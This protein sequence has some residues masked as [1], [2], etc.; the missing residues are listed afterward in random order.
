MK[1]ILFVA[2][3]SI[4][5]ITSC[6]KKT[7]LNYTVTEKNGIKTYRNKNIPSDPNFKITPK[8]VFTIQGYDE[9]ATDTLRNFIQPQDVAVD[10]KGNIYVLDSRLA[11]ITIFDKNGNFLKSIGRKGTG[12]GE[13]KLPWQMIILN[14]TLYVSDNASS[15][16]SVFENKFNFI[17]NF[18]LGNNNTLIVMIPIDSNSF[19]SAT[20][21]WKVESEDTYYVNTT[22]LRDSKFK[23]VKIL[24]EK[25]GKY[26]GQNTNFGDY[27][28]A[29]CV[30]KE[31]IY[32]GTNS[33]NEYSI[34]VLD[35]NGQQKYR[36]NKDFRKITMPTKEKE[37]YERSRNSSNM[38][39][40]D[41]DFKI[42]YKRAIEIFGMFVDKDD[43][44]LIQTPIERNEDNQY[45]FVVDAFKD[46][47]FINRFKM[48]IG[49]GFDFFNS[50]HK[51]WFIGNRIYYQNRE[52]NCV[53]V[54]EY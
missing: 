11:S 17:R 12:P 32:I 38:V 33:I 35:L 21:S 10:S 40:I 54:Y 50:D 51:R 7:E 42:K 3:I 23:I 8:E 14:D 37:E 13:F 4:V 18:T 29:Y 48:E 2:M 39:E 16:L 26:V 22:T 34:D 5:L 15:Q 28:T 47:V 9:N 45:D 46:G 53:T 19:I 41:R 43:H 25:I 36:M 30:G 1:K 31:N 27:T 52:D 49:K 44:L 6:T 24:N 20:Q